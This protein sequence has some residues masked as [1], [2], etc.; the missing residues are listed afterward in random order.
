MPGSKG[1]ARHMKIRNW[2]LTILVGISVAGTLG[3]LM[4]LHS[5]I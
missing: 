3:Y 1:G 2:V 5:G 4:F